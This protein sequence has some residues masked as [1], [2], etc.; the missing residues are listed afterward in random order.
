MSQPR[1][2]HFIHPQVYRQLLRTTAAVQPLSCDEAYLDVT[3]LGD[4]E[5][6]ASD[7]RARVAEATSCP[8]SAG[9]GP[10]PLVARLVGGGGGASRAA[11]ASGTP[12]L[13]RVGPQCWLF[14]A[15]A[16]LAVSFLVC[17]RGRGPQS[18]GKCGARGRREASLTARCWD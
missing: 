17:A 10:N 15:S 2:S 3:G 11:R 12:L 4:P 13:R 7:L 16:L 8:A 14:R 1:I 18:Q 6:I 5:A 9:I